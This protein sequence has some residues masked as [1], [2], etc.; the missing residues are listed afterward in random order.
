MRIVVHIK[1]SEEENYVI[2][3]GFDP[4]LFKAYFGFYLVYIF[5]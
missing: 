4:S 2:D 5:P 3:A 1:Q